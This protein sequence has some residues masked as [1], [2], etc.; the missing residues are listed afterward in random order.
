M[1]ILGEL[2]LSPF[3]RWPSGGEFPVSDY[4]FRFDLDKAIQAVAFLLKQAKDN[5]KNYTWLL[6]LLYIADVESL[7]ESGYPITGDE[8]HAMESGPVLSEIYDHIKGEKIDNWQSYFTRDGYAIKLQE[9]PG[10]G[11]LCPYEIEKL[12][13]L[14]EKH[15]NKSLGD[16]I[17]LTHEFE[18][19]KQNEPSCNTSTPIPLSDILE[20][21]NL[22]DQED[23][24][25]QNAEDTHELE[26]LMSSK[27]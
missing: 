18:E 17:D 4:S 13:E 19:Y 7:K 11:K 3:K 5:T 2:L 10:E 16:M 20:R 8:P 9:D 6:K 25:Q 15:K 1:I 24:I 23:A 12:K 14:W 26:R 22:S 27:N 21:V